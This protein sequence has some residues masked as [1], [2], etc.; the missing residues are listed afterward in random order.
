[1]LAVVALWPGRSDFARCMASPQPSCEWQRERECRFLLPV[2]P[3]HIEARLLCGV[4]NLRARPLQALEVTRRNRY[5]AGEAELGV[6]VGQLLLAA[7]RR[8]L[9]QTL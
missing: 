1:M 6:A 3:L 2:Q 5:E 8:F 7:R 4:L 9:L